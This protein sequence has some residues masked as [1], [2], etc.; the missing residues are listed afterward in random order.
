MTYNKIDAKKMENAK[1]NNANL[2]WNLS[3]AIFKKKLIGGVGGHAPP[4]LELPV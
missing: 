2:H 4:P 1:N 3:S